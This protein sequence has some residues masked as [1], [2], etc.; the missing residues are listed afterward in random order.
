MLFH[1]LENTTVVDCVAILLIVDVVVEAC[2]VFSPR[3]QKIV[4]IIIVTIN[5]RPKQMIRNRS[6]LFVA[7]KE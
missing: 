1:I 5:N 6:L 4:T 2:V 7:L 3:S